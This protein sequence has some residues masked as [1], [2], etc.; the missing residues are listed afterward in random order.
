MIKTANTDE[1][2]SKNQNP[3]GTEQARMVGREERGIRIECCGM[4]RDAPNICKPTSRDF[5]KV[6]NCHEAI[7]L[8]VRGLEF[9]RKG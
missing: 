8:L 9:R 6:R 2:H 3:Q 5:A 7:G 1:S 4:A